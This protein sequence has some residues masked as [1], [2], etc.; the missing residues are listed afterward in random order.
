MRYLLINRRA[1][2]RAFAPRR[3]SGSILPVVAFSLLLIFAFLA[4][5]V[6]VMREF[7]EAGQLRFAARS[8]ALD[9]L[10]FVCLDA[11][12]QM[13]N[14]PVCSASGAFTGTALSNLTQALNRPNGQS[15]E[16]WNQATSNS[17]SGDQNWMQGVTFSPDDLASGA[18]VGNVQDKQDPLLELRVNRTGENG[19]TLFFMPLVF[20]FNSSMGIPVPQSAASAEQSHIV[21]V[22][23]QPAT[24]IGSAA[25]LDSI[26]GKAQ[27]MATARSA[28]FPLAINYDDFKR[29]SL[30]AGSGLF[31]CTVHLSAPQAS[32][33][34]AANDLRGY[35]VNLS[36]GSQ[37]NASYNEAQDPA[38]VNDLTG[39]LLYFDSSPSQP[40]SATLK[41]PAAVENGVQLDRF[42]PP[43]VKANSDLS[44]V[45]S[46]LSLN[47][48]YIVPV[49]REGVSPTTQ[50]QVLGF[51]LLRLTA[52]TATSSGW[53]FSFVMGESLPVLNASCSGL[54]T[55]PNFDGTLLP[56]IYDAQ[57]NPFR[58]RSYDANNDLIAPR[59]KGVV[60]APVVSPRR[61]S[62]DAG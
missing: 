29:A 56:S 27:A 60:L 24:R 42:A 30:S 43:A 31:S 49:V 32:Q 25:P 12:G 2:I 47:K 51:S 6:D 59:P 9:L 58:V 40:V 1:R 11:S 13:Q 26:S 45:I 61:L 37:V 50:C 14:N 33:L 18:A 10:P 52:V 20:A 54:K 8:A 55:I 35:F 57:N 28:T 41:L 5:T 34:S 44:L 38:R 46:Q 17:E 36:N 53:D 39:T 21:E 23:G 15:G 7:L 19:L 3:A 16:A 22:V 62:V 48:C 4:F